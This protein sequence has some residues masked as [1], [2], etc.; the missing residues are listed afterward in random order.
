V[1]VDEDGIIYVV[2]GSINLGIFRF[3]PQGEF[4]H[5]WGPNEVP[6]WGL[7]VVNYIRRR[8]LTD[9]QIQFLEAVTPVSVRNFDIDANGFIYT[10]SPFRTGT[11]MG[12]VRKLN[13][14]GEN[15]LSDEAYF[16]D[17]YINH[18]S[19]LED[20]RPDFIDVAVDSGGFMNL[21]DRN[22]RRVYQFTKD[23]Y[24]ISVFGA[25]GDQRGTFDTPSAVAAVGGRIYVTDERK[26]LIYEFLPTEYILL[27][28]EATLMLEHFELEQSRGLWYEILARN[29]NSRAAYLALGRIA[30]AQG[31]FARAMEYFRVIGGMGILSYS[32]SFAEYRQEYMEENWM[33]VMLAFAALIGMLFLIGNVWG[34]LSA[35]RKGS[36]YTRMESK[37]LFPLYVLTHPTDGFS[38]FKYRKHQSIPWVTAI[39]AAWFT[40][41]TLRFFF[42]GPSFNINNA[43]DYSLLITL[44]QTVGVFAMFVV[45]NWCICS[46]LDGEGTFFEIITTAAYSLLP[47]V[48]T[49]FINIAVSQ[50]LVLD[51]WIFMTMITIVGV[52]WSS[53]LLFC[54][55]Y[56]I[57]DYSVPKTFLSIVL[58]VLGMFIML[59][60]GI[61]FFGLLQQ[62]WSFGASVYRESL[63]RF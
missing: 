43:V 52:V 28:R 13:F 5:F 46:L 32:L 54:G 17:Y 26:N 9:T 12:N 42:L 39:V 35:P 45:V 57:H 51:E 6:D 1:L 23:G 31:D 63:T 37:N 2:A 50:V 25:M 16:G 20:P 7:A 33:L 34:R 55:L 11:S 41:Q 44:L 38:Q 18:T 8:F 22:N 48:L 15:V 47:F 62:V 36:S 58:T 56:A 49:I 61:L 30:D 10:V 4:L 21:L 24:L 40:G 59:F 19:F 27:Y 29:S 53:V 14:L 3:S 60:I